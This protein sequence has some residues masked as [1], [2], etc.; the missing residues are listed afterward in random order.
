MPITPGHTIL[1]GEALTDALWNTVVDYLRGTCLSLDDAVTAL[2]AQELA[3]HMPFL[4][5][6]DQEIFCCNQCGWWC[7]Q[8]EEASEDH[9][10]DEWTCTE[11]C[12]GG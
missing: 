6:L 2:A 4:N 3:D 10:L 5:H 11:C 9:G 1:E 12:N 8:D 7:D